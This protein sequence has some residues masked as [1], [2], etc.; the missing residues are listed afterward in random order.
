MRRDY[1]DCNLIIISSFTPPPPLFP[2]FSHSFISYLILNKLLHLLLLLQ[3]PVVCIPK[4][5]PT[6]ACRFVSVT[7][8][9][10]AVLQQIFVSPLSSC[11]FFR[12]LPSRR[13][14]FWFSCLTL[15]QNPV[16]GDA[17]PA[18]PPPPLPAQAPPECSVRPRRRSRAEMREAGI[19]RARTT[20]PTGPHQTAAPPRSAPAP[21]PRHPAPPIFVLPGMV[22]RFVV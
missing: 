21:P 11:P 1:V 13:D 16:T 22:F 2:P 4:V 7:G 18:A 10:L 15:P 14:S 6:T 9:I 20:H 3:P 8:S 17:P 12:D 19:R 5:T